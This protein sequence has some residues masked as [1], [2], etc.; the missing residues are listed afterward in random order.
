[1]HA[2][3]ARVVESGSHV[4]FDGGDPPLGLGLRQAGA[5]RHHLGKILPIVGGDL[6]TIAQAKQDMA[7]AG[8]DLGTVRRENARLREENEIL[9]KAA[10]YFAKASR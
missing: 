9:K 4:G 10:I 5:R 6:R 7:A 1:M 8:Q 2:D 3:A